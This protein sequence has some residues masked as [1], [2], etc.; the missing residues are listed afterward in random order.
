MPDRDLLRVVRQT[1]TSTDWYSLL[2]HLAG[3]G[4]L[5]L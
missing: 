5:D 3:A 4:I 2:Q 1:A